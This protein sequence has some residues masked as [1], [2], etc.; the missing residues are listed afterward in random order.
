MKRKKRI[1]TVFVLSVSLFRICA[2]GMILRPVISET[3]TQEVIA[4]TE[5]ET[6]QRAFMYHDPV[7]E[8]ERLVIEVSTGM[9]SGPFAWFLP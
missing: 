7:G 1:V 5:K 6:R 3:E 4:F 2:D 8:I 9:F